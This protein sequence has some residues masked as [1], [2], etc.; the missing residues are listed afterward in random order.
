MGS[1]AYVV[2][3][4]L[5][6][7][8]ELYTPEQWLRVVISASGVSCIYVWV[9]PEWKDCHI[10]ISAKFLE[11]SYALNFCI[12]VGGR[13]SAGLTWMDSFSPEQLSETGMLLQ[14]HRKIWKL[15]DQVRLAAGGG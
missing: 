7:L 4:L 15:L 13:Y 9:I 11:Y 5:A 1:T 10:A 3:L 6:W 2:V 12:H 14:G 8:G